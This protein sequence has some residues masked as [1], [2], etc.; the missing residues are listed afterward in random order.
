MRVRYSLLAT[1]EIQ[2]I[3]N[4]LK[5]RSPGGAET[6]LA[7]IRSAVAYIGHTP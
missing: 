7:A 4:Y 6:V 1:H 3:S 2:A 5:T